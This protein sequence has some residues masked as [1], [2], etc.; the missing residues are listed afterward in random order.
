MTPSAFP[1][2]ENPNQTRTA[3]IIIAAAAVLAGVMLL[4]F[5]VLGGW[6]DES[7]GALA[8]AVPTAS[9][10]AVVGAVVAGVA[11]AVPSVDLGTVP[12]SRNVDQTFTL[13][14]SGS[15]QARLGKPRVETLE[16]C[17]PPRPVIGSTTI[18]PGGETTVF[19]SMNMDPG[20]EGPHL[21]RI[22]VPVKGAT[23]ES[24]DL[25]MLVRAEFR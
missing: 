16:G 22:T 23:G 20:M 25:Q 21:F 5:T 10:P 9:G 7:V 14:N 19:V 2:T 17:S 18:D 4:A 3:L 13:Q 11:V 6:E 15:G 12:M 8:M 24:G 1:P